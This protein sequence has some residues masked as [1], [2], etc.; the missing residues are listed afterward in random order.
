MQRK[1][2]LPDQRSV[3]G[4]EQLMFE[5]HDIGQDAEPVRNAPSSGE[6]VKIGLA[7]TRRIRIGVR[8]HHHAVGD[9]RALVWMEQDLDV[10]RE[11]HAV[12]GNHHGATKPLQGMGIGVEH[13]EASNNGHEKRLGDSFDQQGAIAEQQC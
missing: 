6:R 5:R 1:E 7:V 3:A 9:S 12:D 13:T 8:H 10:R 4:G 2:N 11:I